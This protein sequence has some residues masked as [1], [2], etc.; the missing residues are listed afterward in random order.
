MAMSNNSFLLVASVA[1]FLGS[2]IPTTHAAAELRVMCQGFSHVEGDLILPETICAIA[3]II[4]PSLAPLEDGTVGYIGGY[5][6]K[7]DILNLT[8]TTPDEVMAD[9][10]AAMSLPTIGTKIV[11][12]QDDVGACNVTVN[13]QPCDF[14]TVCGNT[15]PP[16]INVDC[17]MIEGGRALPGCEPVI[18]VFYPFEGYYPNAEIVTVDGGSSGGPGNN[19]TGEPD[20]NSTGGTENPEED[21]TDP[22]FHPSIHI[23]VM[24]IVLLSFPISVLL[25]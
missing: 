1:A 10:A 9:Q 19:V 12:T 11:V 4:T 2:L 20:E 15:D 13:D 16:S 7:Y 8:G 25:L 6:W 17:S 18:D 22:A 21:T 5:S 24:A 14:C 23:S 3:E